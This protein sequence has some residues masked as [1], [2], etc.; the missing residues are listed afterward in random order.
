MVIGNLRG[1]I[2]DLQWFLAQCIMSVI[3]NEKTNPSKDPFEEHSCEI[4]TNK[5][6]YILC[7]TR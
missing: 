5:I 4:N 7:G 6:S 1:R 3:V 2:S